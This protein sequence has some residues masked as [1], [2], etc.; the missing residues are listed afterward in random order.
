MTESPRKNI[1]LINLSLFTARPRFTPFPDF[2]A[3]VHISRTFS[4]TILQCLSKAFT[5]ANSL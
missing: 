1:L 2:G 4:N 5:L 3:S